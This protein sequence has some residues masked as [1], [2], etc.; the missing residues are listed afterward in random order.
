MKKIGTGWQSVAYDLGNGRVLKRK[1]SFWSQFLVILV[2]G[3][4]KDILK[5]EIT[6]VNKDFKNSLLGLSFILKNSNLDQNFLG[7]PLIH[8]GELFYLQDKV[9]PASVLLKRYS[10]EESKLFLR[11]YIYLI[12]YLWGFGIHEKIFNFH[13]NTGVDNRGR[14]ILIDLG[15]LSFDKDQVISDLK[16]KIW[17]RRSSYY[18][19]AGSPLQQFYSDLVESELTVES[20]EDTWQGLIK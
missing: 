4:P 14:V 17:K 9:I 7:N 6:R 13:L 11:R 8:D 10:L 16:R 18:H 12:K 3:G 19:L 5:G 2:Q 15:E 20:L 1:R